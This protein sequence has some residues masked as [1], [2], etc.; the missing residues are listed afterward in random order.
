MHNFVPSPIAF[1]RPDVEDSPYQD[2]SATM[3]VGVNWSP[4]RACSTMKA[5]GLVTDEVEALRHR[6]GRAHPVRFS[7][8]KALTTRMR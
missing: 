5:T 1:V 6:W 7:D 2:T 3:S 4:V 8:G